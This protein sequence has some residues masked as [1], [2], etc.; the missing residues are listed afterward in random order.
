MRNTGKM[1][2]TDRLNEDKP[3]KIEW[4]VGSDTSKHQIPVGEE[5]AFKH[6]EEK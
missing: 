4:M 1:P 6:D 3:S 2:K 5:I